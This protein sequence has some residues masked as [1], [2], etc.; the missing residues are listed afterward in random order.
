MN[1]NDDVDWDEAVR[2]LDEMEQNYVS[3]GRSGR[4]C[5]IITIWPIKDRVA[6]KERT[7]KLYDEIMALE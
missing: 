1:P 5:L 2:Y 7:K 3:I 6:N 4:A